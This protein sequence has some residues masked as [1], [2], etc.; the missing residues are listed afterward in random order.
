MVR[1]PALSCF[2]FL[3]FFCSV[4]WLFVHC[5]HLFNNL[6]IRKKV[7][8]IIPKKQKKMCYVGLVS[9]CSVNTL[10][11][12][13]GWVSLPSA[14]ALGWHASVGIRWLNN[15]SSFSRI[16]YTE[17]ALKKKHNCSSC[18]RGVFPVFT[19]IIMK[20]TEDKDSKLHQS[21]AA[22]T[23]IQAVLLGSISVRPSLCPGGKMKDDVELLHIFF[24]W[25]HPN[26]DKT[27]SVTTA[28]LGGWRERVSEEEDLEGGCFWITRL[29]HRLKQRKG[30]EDGSRARRLST[31]EL[32]LAM[33][34][35]GGEQAV[36]CVQG[37]YERQHN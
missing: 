9:C 32:L 2:V 19:W 15:Q 14:D 29:E 28:R 18:R 37:F 5:V 23:Y 26:T 12:V 6:K 36:E 3:V 10:F 8:K 35:S 4:T 34:I 7:S 22:W 16:A 17:M 11:K 24:L 27:D 13:A 31:C 33:L 20:I 30:V 25:A 21:S 1:D